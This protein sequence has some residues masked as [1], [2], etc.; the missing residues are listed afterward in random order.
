MEGCKMLNKK[1]LKKLGETVDRLV[2]TDILARGAIGCIYDSARKEL[3]DEPLTFT[4]AEELSEH[5]D[6]GDSVFITTGC[7]YPG[8]GAGETDGPLGAASLARALCISR[9]AKPIIVVEPIHEEMMLHTLR[10]IGLNVL[11]FADAQRYERVA[12]IVEFPRGDE[13]NR[14]TELIEKFSPSAVISIERIGRNSQGVY[15]NMTGRDISECTAEIDDLIEQAKDT[16]ILTLGIGDGG[17]E[18]GMGKVVE[19][20]RKEVAYGDR[21][22][23]PCEGGIACVTETDILVAASVSNW[24]AHGIAAVLAGKYENTDVLHTGADEMR[25]MRECVD[26]GGVGM[27][28]SPYP[29]P[30]CDDLPDTIH[31]QLVEFLRYSVRGALMRKYEG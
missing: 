17:N 23:C 25:A 6:E 30:F 5:V 15:H 8:L 18:V 31:A 1:I 16:G 4:A 20:V 21:C 27:D 11:P 19:T 12:T 22:Q 14:S 28:G 13:K 29:A 24:G 26:A 10:G 2:T 9:G 7:T 3:N